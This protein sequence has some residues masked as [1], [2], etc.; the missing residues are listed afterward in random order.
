M[1]DNFAAQ[2]YFDLELFMQT[3]GETRLGGDAMDECLALWEKWS[4]LLANRI[5]R[6]GDRE[7]LAVW[8]DET[9][10]KAVDAAWEESPS[11][12]F[13]LNA[14]A[15]T[16]CM[17]ATHDR[18]PEIAEAGCAPVPAASPGLAEA[19]TAEGLP[20]RAGEGMEY[21][22]KYTMVTRHPFGGACEI[23]ALVSSCPRSGQMNDSVVELG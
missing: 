5:V 1:N 18:L 22:R 20:A 16:L 11:H 19:L 17:C 15:Q 9:V 14:L 10:E 21:A 12:G 8:L 13:R 6:D 7:Y 4:A 23:C 2:P 3:A